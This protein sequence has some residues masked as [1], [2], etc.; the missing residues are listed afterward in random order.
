[1]KSTAIILGLAALVA[2]GASQAVSAA[3]PGQRASVTVATSDLD[4]RT[5]A[6]KATLRHRLGLAAAEV[7]GEASAADPE[8]RRSIRDCRARVVEQATREIATRL[9]S[10]R[11]AAR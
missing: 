2:A 7:C 5:A 11:L 4:L 8:G 3:M 10:G 1:M 9:S 6:G